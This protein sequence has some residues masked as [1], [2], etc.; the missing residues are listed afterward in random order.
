MKVIP[1]FDLTGHNTF[2]IKAFAKKFSTFSDKIKLKDLLLKYNDIPVL[3]LGGGSNILFTKNVDGL[4]LHNQVKGIETI[5]E[6]DSEVWIRAG[7]GETWHQL[8]LECVS[9]NFG[10]IENLSLIPGSVGASP[11]QNIGAYGVEVKDVFSELQA[12]HLKEKYIRTFTAD[13]CKF[14]YRESVFKNELKDQFVIMNV[15][16]RLSKNPLFN[17]SYGPVEKQLEVMNIQQLSVKAVS[18]AV[19]AIRKSK[20][21]DPAFLGNAG[22]FFKNPVISTTKFNELKSENP[23]MPNFVVPGG[24]K[25]PAAWLIE[26]CGFKGI[27]KGDTGCYEKQ[28]LVIVNYGNA[29]GSD[30]FAFSESI[31]EK[32]KNTFEIELHRE[33]NVV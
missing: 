3:I 1:N 6:N 29:T 8:V 19:I 21:P 25:I 12:F 15:T 9:K 17:I 10:G 4:V 5:N 30:V 27:R 26:Q 24:I 20:L 13:E 33:V 16:Y 2:H 23:S 7:A 28:P 22:S 31:I 11:M 14:G 32:V 18:D